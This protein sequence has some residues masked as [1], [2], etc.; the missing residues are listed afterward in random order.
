MP[1]NQP[2]RRIAIVGTGVIGASWAAYYLSRGFD[3][4]A[5]V[6]DAV[7]KEAQGRS[8]DELARDENSVL[9]ALLKQRAAVGI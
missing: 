8:V 6:V 5:T 9:V 1:L 3:M 7:L 2:V 4:V